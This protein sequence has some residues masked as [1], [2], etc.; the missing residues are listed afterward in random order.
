MKTK[1]LS[2][3]IG[4]RESMTVEWKPSLS[5]INEIIE[6]ITAFSNTEGGRLFVGISKDGKAVGVSIGKDTIENLVNRVAQ[7]TEP[8]IHPRVTVTKS[9]DK[10]IIVIDVKESHDK[11]VLANGRPY[12]RV[13]KSTRQMG[14]DEYEP[15]I[16]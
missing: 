7:H 1:G 6:S 4:A 10:E 12:I 11:L 2:K 9:G 16:L 3:L 8:K 13:G 5:Q 14:K 15:F